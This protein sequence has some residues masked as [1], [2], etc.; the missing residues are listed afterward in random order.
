MG[1]HMAITDVDQIFTM[2]AADL[3]DHGECGSR[4]YIRATMHT[5]AEITLCGHHVRE[6][7]GALRPKTLYWVDETEALNVRLDV[8]P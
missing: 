8:S 7:E 1:S 2:T 5:L 3:C 6:I 4:A